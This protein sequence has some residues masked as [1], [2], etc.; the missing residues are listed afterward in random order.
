MTGNIVTHEE[1]LA[2]PAVEISDS[3]RIS[4]EPLVSVLVVTYN[5]EAYIAQNIEGVLAQN[6]DFPIEFI[7]GEDKS[8]DRTLEICLKYQQD[9][10]DVIRVVTWHANLGISANYLRC[11][12]RVRGKYVAILEGDDYWTDPDK[13]SKQVALMEQFPETSMCGAK[14]RVL[15]EGRLVE[16]IGQ[17]KSDIAYS[18]K[19]V[20]PERKSMLQITKHFRNTVYPD[21]YLQFVCALQG[22]VRCLPE[23]MSVWRHHPGG[24]CSDSPLILHYE[25]CESLCNEFMDIVDERERELVK[26]TLHVIMYKR[27]HLLINSGNIS[28]ARMLAQGL[29]RRLVRHDFLRAVL[30]LFHVGLPKVYAFLRLFGQNIKVIRFIR[31]FAS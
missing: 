31:R 20:L 11:L 4:P 27:C 7:I 24:V 5:H 26:R 17:D 16:E 18:L 23:V 22:D 2:I 25:R 1:M 30:L 28:E 10:P 19:D 14:T 15:A 13:L 21:W 8:T 12:G 9:H 3:S 6:C 29:L